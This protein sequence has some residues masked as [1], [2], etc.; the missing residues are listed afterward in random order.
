MILD[1]LLP[2]G[3][4]PGDDEYGARNKF[5]PEEDEHLLKLVKESG[6]H[7]NWKVISN[8]MWTRSPRQCRERFKNYLD[9]ELFHSEWTPEEDRLLYEKFQQFGNKWN[10]ISKY[11]KGRSGNSIRNRWQILKKTTYKAR[12]SGTRVPN[13]RKPQSLKETKADV[14]HE[15]EKKESTMPSPCPNPNIL[16]EIFN[17]AIPSDTFQ[18]IFSGTFGDPYFSLFL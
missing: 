17:Q 18:D 13:Q 3:K 4:Y 14:E 8:K 16:D 6:S 12:R 1:R 10:V 11:I 15:P 2:N 9:P 5:T 7:P